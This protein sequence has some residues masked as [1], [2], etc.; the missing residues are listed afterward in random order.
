[1]HGSRGPNCPCVGALERCDP[2]DGARDGKRVHRGT[3]D[4]PRH[5]SR[6]PHQGGGA[7]VRGLGTRGAPPARALVPRGRARH[8]R[9][10]GPSG[11]RRQRGRKL[12]VQCDHQ[13][14]AATPR[15]AAR[16]D[17]GP[18]GHGA[19]VPHALLHARAEGTLP[20]RRRH[21]RDPTRDRDDRAGRGIR[22]GR[23]LHLRGARRRRLRDQRVEDDD[24]QRHH[25]RTVRRRRQDRPR[26]AAQGAQPPARRRRSSG[27][28]AGAQPGED[29]PARAGDGRAVLQRPPRARRQPPRRGGA[30]I[31]LPHVQPAAGAPVDRRVVTGRGGRRDSMRPSST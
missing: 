8:P 30:G 22:P 13:R 25:C 17:P 3:R 29:R 26:A 24:L 2:E 9:H 19:P 21:R 12:Q 28:G 1:M 18:H 15:G 16:W 23:N 10:P 14:G 11:I 20:P 27:P 7:A 31:R 6:L 5:G 4:L